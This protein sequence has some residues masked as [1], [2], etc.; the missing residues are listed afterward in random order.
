MGERER[1][2]ILLP[3]FPL[4]DVVFFPET[5]LPLH[6]FEPRYRE[7]LSDA[8]DGD[9]TIGIQLLDPARPADPDGRPAVHAIG[10][11][12]TIID[13]E[14]LDDGRSNIVL[15]GEFRYRIGAERS[16]DGKPYRVAEVDEIPI[17][18]LP[19]EGPST[20]SPKDMRRLLTQMV[21]RLAVS[22]GRAEASILPP[23]LS[24]EGL[25]NEAAS[26]LGLDADD[27]YKLL[28][29]DRL[30]ERYTWVVSHIAAIQHRLDLLAPY[31]R[32]ES[33]ARW[34]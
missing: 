26:R 14:P 4:P 19:R 2:H 24:D 20:P 16:E 25:V 18:P 22:V 7:L 3:I 15:K 29:M 21:T 31:R 28:A 8:L 27:R 6:V 10:C 9:R 23:D 34:N 30:A 17:A 13:Y 1:R 12:G 5:E 11:A 32:S 33:E